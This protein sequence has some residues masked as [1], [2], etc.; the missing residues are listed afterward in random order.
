MPIRHFVSG[1]A[2]RI[3]LL[4]GIGCVT[5]GAATGPDREPFVDS[6]TGGLPVAICSAPATLPANLGEWSEGAKLFTGL[7]AF[8]RKTSTKSAVAQAY[9]DQ[10]MRYLWAFNHDE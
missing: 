6:A 10:G 2:A 4:L 5:L 9:F 8:H 1:H 3:G 7:G